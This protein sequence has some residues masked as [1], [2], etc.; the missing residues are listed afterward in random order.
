MLRKRT[1]R[2]SQPRAGIVVAMGLPTKRAGTIATARR[3]IGFDAISNRTAVRASN[4]TRGSRDGGSPARRIVV[5]RRD[6]GFDAI[7]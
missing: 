2:V 7:W 6:V 3:D 5:T 1:N 4:R